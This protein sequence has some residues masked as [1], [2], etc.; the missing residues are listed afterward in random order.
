MNII[1]IAIISVLISVAAQFSLKAGMSS[2]PVTAAMSQAITLRSAVQ[3]LFQPGVFFGFALY[4]AGA[5]VWL[6]VLSEWD[7]S[8]AYPL[9]GLGFAATAV[10]GLLMGEAV[11]AKR[12]LGVGLICLG[13][14]L[15]AR[16]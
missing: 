16:S 8:K 6:K 11:S 3:I 15:V 7:V 10:I 5:V 1:V 9:V 14:V 4:G 2:A 12:L 13:V